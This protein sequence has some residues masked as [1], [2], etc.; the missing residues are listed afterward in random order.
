MS[1][2]DH[3]IEAID[4]FVD[5]YMDYLDGMGDAPSLAD[6]R[7][8]LRSEAAARARILEASSG[9]LLE[10][11]P[12]VQDVVARH[13]G[14]D[15]AG[16][17]IAIN[18]T[19]VAALRLELKLPL[20]EF[21]HQVQVAGGDQPL[22][23]WFQAEKNPRIEVPQPTVTALAAVL[24][25]AVESFEADPDV[26]GAFAFELEGLEAVVDS[27]AADHERDPQ[28]TMERVRRELVDAG[29]RAD[30]VSE[31]QLL[32]IVRAILRGLE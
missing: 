3:D 7:P 26:V 27:W 24:R 23:F 2:E 22:K 18:G 13:F 25:T 19:R 28:Q 4:T 9:A 15:R 1:P 14:F 31:E 32:A 20:D 30:D 17:P 5:S 6:L 8:E 21:V 11:D 12:T 29:Y 10:A 16:Q